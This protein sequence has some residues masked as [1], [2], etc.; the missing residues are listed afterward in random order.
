MNRTTF[1]SS[2]IKREKQNTKKQHEYGKRSIESI[3]PDK[4]HKTG[5]NNHNPDESN[6]WKI[7]YLCCEINKRYAYETCD[8]HFYQ[9]PGPFKQRLAG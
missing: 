6:D 8:N 1:A 2:S 9:P 5:Y 4:I 3:Y 7:R